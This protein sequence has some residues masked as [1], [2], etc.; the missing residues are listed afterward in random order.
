MNAPDG[1]VWLLMVSSGPVF[2]RTAEWGWALRR[3]SGMQRSSWGDFAREI[4]ISGA[5]SLW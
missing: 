1:I 2:L 4:G 3:V 5:M